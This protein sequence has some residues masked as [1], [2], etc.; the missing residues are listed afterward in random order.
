MITLTNSLSTWGTPEFTGAFS[1]EVGS[2]NSEQLPLQQGLMQSSHI[3]DSGFSV[4]ILNSS[5]TSNAI[6]VKTGIFYSG[7][8]AGSCCSDDPTPLN[9]QTEYCELQIE[10]SKSTAEAKITLLSADI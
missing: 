8:I 9:E 7:V 2:L 4:V 10:I 1:D 6:S 5:E 3:S